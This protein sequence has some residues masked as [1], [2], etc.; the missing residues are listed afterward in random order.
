LPHKELYKHPDMLVTFPGNHDQPR[1]LTVA[2]DDIHRLMMNEAFTLTTRR[3]VHLYYGDEVA[4]IGGNDPDNRPDFQGGWAG[5]PIDDFTPAGRT[6]DAATVFNFT[7]ELLH[8][9]QAHTALQ[10]GDLTELLINQDQYAYLRTSRDEWVLVVLNRA[11]SAKAIPIEV[12]DLGMADGTHLK[13]FAAD[14]PDTIVAGGKITIE[15][16]KEIQIY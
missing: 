1:L 6:G 2:K 13:S 10:N 16:P 14:S 12:D 8:F 11:G 7:R 3:V 4:M 9:R 15:Q 5:D